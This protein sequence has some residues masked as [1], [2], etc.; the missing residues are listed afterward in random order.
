VIL[1]VSPTGKWNYDD[2]EFRI[3]VEK[4]NCEIACEYGIKIPRDGYWGHCRSK[5]LGLIGAQLQKRI[6]VLMAWNKGG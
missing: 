5:D 3:M 4:L 2:S 1:F 6:R